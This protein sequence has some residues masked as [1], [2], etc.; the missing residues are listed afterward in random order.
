M[1]SN[2]R[3]TRALFNAIAYDAA[4]TWTIA[5][6]LPPSADPSQPVELSRQRTGDRP[7]VGG[8]DV[9]Y[10][11]RKARGK[12]T[13]RPGDR[14]PSLAPVRGSRAPSAPAKGRAGQTSVLPSGSWIGHHRNSWRGTAP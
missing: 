6:E 3:R 1:T 5:I 12:L 11:A 10:L 7:G 2:L 9:L 4:S 14:E 8:E 13:Q